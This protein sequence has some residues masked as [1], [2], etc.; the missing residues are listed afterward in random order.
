MLLVLLRVFLRFC[1]A[2]PRAH[3]LRTCFLLVFSCVP[4]LSG[5]LDVVDALVADVLGL[6]RGG[7]VGK[8]IPSRGGAGRSGV[9]SRLID[10]ESDE[11]GTGEGGAFDRPTASQRV[12]SAKRVKGSHPEPMP[13]T[14]EEALALIARL[15]REA[16]MR[17]LPTGQLISGSTVD[18]VNRVLYS[19]IVGGR[20]FSTPITDLAHHISTRHR[21]YTIHMTYGEQV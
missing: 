17:E 14:M 9:K 11:E 15:K 2:V 12:E 5:S 6:G 4:I 13:E 18:A 21:G 7:D 8:A 3:P 10:E 1:K 20:V 19:P 16:D